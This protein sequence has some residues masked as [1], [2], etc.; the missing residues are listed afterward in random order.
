MAR[1]QLEEAGTS[2]GAL[3]EAARTGEPQEIAVDGQVAAIVLSGAAYE[4]L[5]GRRGSFVDFMRSSPLV[6]ADLE[7]ERDRTPARDVEP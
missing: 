1:W 2:L 3:I 7:I 5:A 6:G 4:R